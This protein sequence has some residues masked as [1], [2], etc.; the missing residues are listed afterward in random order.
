MAGIRLEFSQ[1]GDFDSFDILRSISPM[2][3]AALP[4]PLATGLLTMYYV[5]TAVVEGAAYY[6]RARV[7][8]DGASQVSDE[9]M[10]LA[11]ASDPEFAN[12]TSLLH[13]DSAG[14]GSALKDEKGLVWTLHG[15]AAL[16]DS[17]YKFAPK[18][19]SSPS[20]AAN[21][22]KC[23]G[24]NAINFAASDKITIEFFFKKTDTAGNACILAILPSGVE[25]WA[26]FVR[27]GATMT[28]AVYDG[29]TFIDKGTGIAINT[30]VHF[31]F[32]KDGASN[33]VY[34]NGVVLANQTGSK[35]ITTSCDL[36]LGMNGQGAESFTG[37][38][39]EFRVTKNVARYTENFTPPYAPFLSN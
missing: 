14:T 12:V 19:L 23:K 17:D 15:T 1:F 26:F 37:Y 18:S 29:T 9:I 33:K 6:Y 8:R 28:V 35:Q 30:W 38:I 20:G 2:S 7:W 39:D 21:Y 5:D 22:A 27:S 10:I 25:R 11:T 13:F 31:A 4:A 3:V 32:V 24:T 16:S 36:Y 34:I